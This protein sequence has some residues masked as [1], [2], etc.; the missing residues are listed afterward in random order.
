MES[1]KVIRVEPSEKSE[2]AAGSTVK[3]YVSI[4]LEQKEVP[5]LIGKTEAEAKEAIVA[6]GLKYTATL[7]K[8]DSSKPN[9]TIIE[10]S[11]VPGSIVDKDTGITIT[12]NQFDEYKTGSINVNVSAILGGYTVKYDEE[13]NAIKPKSVQVTLLLDGK[14]LAT[15][16]TTEDDIK[17]NFSIESTGS[18]P[19]TIQ[20]KSES[21]SVLATKTVP[22]FT[23]GESK[24][25]P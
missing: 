7:N 23:A 17:L 3:V 4:G 8:S 21:G 2:L 14:E 19:V 24:N 15:K 13:G 18:K 20:I 9:N 12:L 25:I 16:N 11:I 1:G 6:A 10:Q 5:N 22:S